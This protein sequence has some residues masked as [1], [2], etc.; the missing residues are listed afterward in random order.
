LDF[1]QHY[2]TGQQLYGN[3][4]FASNKSG[5]GPKGYQR[6]D[7]RIKEEVCELLTSHPEIDPS[8][9]D[10][11]VSSS[12]ITLTG[13]ID[14]RHERRLIEDLAFSV[15]GVTEVNNQL[16]VSDAQQGSVKSPKA[17][18]ENYMSTRRPDQD[19]PGQS[20]QTSRST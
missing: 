5:R 7:E 20:G 9:V 2:G 12:E 14:N 1:G 8:E 18:S 11:Q 3:D 4:T 10:I 15:S 17:V 16:R 19:S 6:S 13:T